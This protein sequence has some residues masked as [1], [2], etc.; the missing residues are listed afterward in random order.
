MTR[1]Q[2]CPLFCALGAL[3]VYA[4]SSTKT[5]VTDAA[6][7]ALDSSVDAAEAYVIPMVDVGDS[8]PIDTTVPTVADVAAACT[9]SAPELQAG[10]TN[11]AYSP[12]F[13]TFS[14]PD[15][16]G[17]L[18]TGGNFAYVSKTAGDEY[19]PSEVI[20]GWQWNESAGADGYQVQT[21]TDAEQVAMS[22]II[23]LGIPSPGVY[24]SSVSCGSI[25]ITAYLPVP[26][27][28]DC[29][30]DG[31]T[32]PGCPANC[33]LGGPI[34]GPT[35]MPVGPLITYTAAGSNDCSGNATIPQGSFQVALTSVQ[36]VAEDGGNQTYYQAHGEITATLIEQGDA[37]GTMTMDLHF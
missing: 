2:I 19:T 14:A 16:A 31:W 15:F 18:C 12:L 27:G 28:T 11:P 9:V 21:P 13:G 35:C 34:L 30:P 4:C 37:G 33:E 36:G 29:H 1:N 25:S 6:H 8:H 24:D 26:A 3:A 7:D 20:L 10:M 22:F 32:G 23:G 17:A 5:P